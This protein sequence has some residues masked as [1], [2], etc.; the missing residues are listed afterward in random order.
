M[1]VTWFVPRSDLSDDQ[2]RAVDLPLTAHSLILGAPGSG[3][4]LVLLH[5]AKR[6]IDEQ[7]IPPERLRILV[8]TNTLKDYIRSTLTLLDIP[9]TCVTTFDHWCREFYL[10][11]VARK[12]PFAQHSPDFDAIR[13]GVLNKLRDGAF[14]PLPLP[15]TEDEA[16]ASAQDVGIT[17][18]EG[19][20]AIRAL[21]QLF[22]ESA[23]QVSSCP[24]YEA[25]LVDEGQ[26]LTPE[27]F[28]IL[29]RISRHVTVC[30]DARQQLYEK[31]CEEPD[32][33]K[34]LGL[35]KCNLTILGAYRC[36]PYISR[37]A[38]SLLR[39][40]AE[41]QA[42][43]NQTKT[44]Q[45]EK[46]T[47]LL[48]IAENA[49][50]E[51]NRLAQIIK[52]RQ[53]TGDRI[54]ILFPNNAKL[55]SLARLLTEAGLEVEVPSKG[56]R[57]TEY[58]THDFQSERPKLMT[59]YGAKGLTF[60]TVIMPRL[61]PSSFHQVSPERLEKLLFVGIT[62]ATRWVYMSTVEGPM[63]PV[64]LGLAS[65]ERDQIITIQRSADSLPL[66]GGPARPPQPKAP[67]P[68][69]ALTDLL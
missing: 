40:P 24:F 51:K 63:L 32:I 17:S 31:R 42:F 20:H 23:K 56:G 48:Y 14:T 58:P 60:E 68:A 7:G 57:P 10:A 41:R 69:D 39:D 33:L 67:Q 6:M 45:R 64:V 28:E 19:E 13:A 66:A 25:A 43:L 36:C 1:S 8:F 49:N 61:V 5:R 59:Y 55:F 37:L 53:L 54:A 52:D 65:L 44:V 38:A 30:M 29:K 62:R 26:D 35:R 3:K 9:E 47:P 27:A 11:F 34:T 4:T 46:L 15:S 16:V 21:H 22:S 2:L 12:V 50:E 18:T